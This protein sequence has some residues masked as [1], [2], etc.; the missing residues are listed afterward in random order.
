MY[1]RKSND[2]KIEPSGTPASTVDQLE[3]WPLR[4]TCWN[5]LINKYILINIIKRT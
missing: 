1:I 4:T 2:P 5:L 3:H